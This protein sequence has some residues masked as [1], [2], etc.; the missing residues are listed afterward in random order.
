MRTTVY[1]LGF[2]KMKKTD[3]SSTAFCM[4]SKGG[5]GFTL[6]ELLV[7]IAI[8]ALLTGGV[9]SNFDKY[10]SAQRVKQTALTLKN[11]L[12]L[13]QNKALSGQKPSTGCTQL[14]GFNVIFT[15]S[16]YST[17]ATCDSGHSAGEITTI[18]LPTAITF[19]PVPV[20]ILF[21]VLTRGSA[22]DVTLTLT[23]SKGTVYTVS[24]KKGG[25]IDVN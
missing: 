22:N 23:N 4:T 17:Q 5:G 11:D 8:M 15:A 3:L 24:V 1:L 25:D 6:V 13:A 20:P 16:T 14:D 10:N 19:S 21:G 7:S 2:V 12:R 18:T 9:L